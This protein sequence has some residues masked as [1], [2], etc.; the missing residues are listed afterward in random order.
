[1]IQKNLS[2]PVHSDS[3]AKFTTFDDGSVTYLAI[4]LFEDP[5]SETQGPSERR[6]LLRMTGIGGA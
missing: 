4:S 1:L 2:N 3:S 5:A 6:T